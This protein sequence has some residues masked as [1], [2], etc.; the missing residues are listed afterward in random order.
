M[1]HR[2][3]P[4]FA[5][6]ARCELL[7]P[8]LLLSAV[9][10]AGEQDGHDHAVVDFYL[11]T[12]YR[13][14]GSGTFLTGPTA[15]E[16]FQIASDYLAAHADDLGLTASDL[17]G[18]VVSSQYTDQ[19]SGVTHIYLR[20]THDGL[21]V[22]NADLSVNV[23]ALGEIINVSS[24][25]IG[26]PQVVSGLTSEFLIG[27]P[28][29]FSELCND[30]GLTLSA[31]DDAQAKLVYVPTAEGLELAWRLN[32]QTIDQAHW[33][34]AFVEAD[35]GEPIYVDDLSSDFASYNVFASP[36][37]SPNEG[38][39]TLVVDP[40]DA[41]ASP[42]GW[43][44]TNG[45][46]GAEFTDTRGNNASVQEDADHNDTGG[47][48]PDGGLSLTFDFPLDTSQNPANFQSAA[49]TNMF[50]WI[51][52]LHDI[53]YQYGFTEAAGNFQVNN[54]GHG[55]T[56]N[57][58]VMGDIQDG[59]GGGPSFVTPPDG[60]S[61]RMQMYLNATVNP[62]RDSALDNTVLI[63]EYGHG[64]SERLTGGPAMTSGLNALQSTG[65]SE[66][67]SDWWALMLTQD[68]SD[69]KTAAYPVGNWYFGQG[70]NG[71][72]ARRFPYSFDMSVNPLTMADFNNATTRTSRHKMGEVW[73]SALWDMNWLLID[74]YGFSSD[75]YH[76][77]GGNNLALQLVMDALKLQG[78]NPSYLDGRDAIL[79][80]DLAL[81]GGQNQA[82]IWTAFARRG[83]GFSASDGGGASATSVTEAFDIPGTISGT[84]FR[85]D[86]ADGTRDAGEPGL[87]GWTVYR[88]LNNNGVQDVATVTTFNSTDIPKA[89]TDQGL[90]FSNIVISG[91]SGSIV[92]VNIAVSITHPNDADLN[93][94]LI[95][96]SGALVILS[97]FLGGT[98]DN[99]TSTVFDDE[100]ATYVTSASAPFTGSF[101]PFFSLSQLDGNSPNG[102]WKLRV[103][104]VAAGNTGTLLGWSMQVSYGNPDPTAVTDANGNYTFFGSGN[105][106]HH[107]R[108]IVQP[109]FTRTAPA[110]GVLDV[111]ISSGQPVNGQNF[112]NRAAASVSNTS[113]LEDTLSSA[114]VLNPPVSFGTT[115]FKISGITGGTLFQNNGTTPINNGDFITVAQGQAG[116]K[117]LPSANSNSTGSFVVELSKN[118]TSVA[119]DASPATCSITVTPVGDTPQVANITTLED[120]LSGAIVVNRNANDGTE[121]THFKI[122]DITGG[123][124]FKND[125][126]TPISNNSFLTF[127]EAQAGVKFLP[128]SN[129]TTSG[130]FDVESSQNGSTVAAQSGKATSTINVTPVG[131]TPQVANIATLENTLSGAI[132]LNRHAA[133]GSEVTH[134]RISGITNGTLFKND[135]VT[136]I[137]NGDFLLFAEGQS[138]VKFLPA[139]N[140]TAT[141][142]FD[143]ESSQDG[144]TVA[145]QSGKATSTITVTASLSIAD[146]SVVE[147]DAGQ[148]LANFTVMLSGVSGQTVTVDFAT[149]SNTAIAASDYT[150]STGTL[151]FAPGETIKSITVPILGDIWDEVDESFFVNLSNASNAVIADGQAIGTITD[152]DAAPS[153]SINDISVVEGNSGQ[154]TASFTVILSATS[155]QAV[156]VDYST[157]DQTAGAPSDYSAVSGTLTFAPGETTKTITV[158]I[159]PDAIDELDETFVANLSNAINATITDSQGSGTIT[160]DDPMP[161][162]SIGDAAVLEGNA[163]QT[164]MTFTVTL[165]TTSSRTISVA[166]VTS[167]N[168]ATAPIEYSAN[169]GSLTFAPGETTKM[170]NVQVQGDVLD[171]THETFFVNLSNATN[172]SLLDGQAIGTITDDDAT[173]SLSINDVA[174][175]EGNSGTTTATF[176]VTLSAISAQTVTVDY[177]TA[178]NTATVASD[179]SASFGTL[180]FAPGE[181]T[182]TIAVEVLGDTVDEPNETFQVNLTGAVG[183]IISDNR[184]IGTITD[185]DGTPTLSVN[186]VIVTEGEPSAI[187]TVTLSAPSSQLVTVNF[188]T[189]S[190]TAFQDFIATSGTL[191]FAAGE[192]SKSITVP[193]NEDLF[194][195]ADE[196]FFVVLSTATNATVADGYGAA[197]ILD[198]DEAPSLSISNSSVTEGNSGTTLATFT[199]TLSSA[200][201]RTVMV[202]YATAD[203]TAL[204]ASDYT[205]TFGTLT[206]VAGLTSKT[207]TIPILGDLL[208][209]PNETFHLNLS[210]AIN[211]SILG[212]QGLGAILDND[213]SPSLSINDVTVV[214]GNSGETSATFTVKLSAV[215]GQ[216]VTVNYATAN[217]TA[218]ATADYAANSGMLTFAAGETTKTITVQ[219]TGDSLDESNESFFVNLS[220][221]VNATILDSQ[222]LGTISD[223]DDAPSLSIDDVVVSE[224]SAGATT[225]TFTV[226]LATASGQAV[227]V[228]YGTAN[229]TAL[230]PADYTATTGT[231]TFPAGT[232]TQPISVAIRPDLIDEL[233][234]TFFVI[235][236]GATN[237]S[238]AD[239]RATGTI[240]D[241]DAPPTMSIKDVVVYE[242]NSG[243]ALATFTVS[244]S[245]ASSHAISV[246]YST[247][248]N[249]A[250]A[251]VDYAATSG[252]LILAAGT[253]SKNFTVPIFGDVLDEANE[254]FF[255]NL[256]NPI[257]ASLADDQ[258]IGTIND[259]DAAPSLKIN[260]VT[261]TEGNSGTANAT[262]TVTLSAA[263]GQAVGV[264]F[265][266]ANSTAL[267]GNDYEAQSGTLLFAPGEKT[268]TVAIAVIGDTLDEANE[269]YF[270][271]LSSATNASLADS[272]GTG[273]ITDNDAAPTLSIN[274][275]TILEGHSG[276]TTATFTV[277]LSA[278]SGQTVS[279]KYATANNT[280]TASADYTAT[281]GTLTFAAGVVSKTITVSIRGDLL[282]ELDEFFFVNLTNP[283]NAS[284]ADSQ[285]RGTITDDD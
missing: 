119:T 22:M 78:T 198:N 44:D 4:S 106:T 11:P 104:D 102:T 146:T 182:K 31:M 43:H 36:L 183:G 256:S 186:D 88:D 32:V 257:N 243:Q 169:S 3:S 77:T 12:Q 184:G 99:Y 280:A 110:S 75:F 158:P 25:F 181:T 244:L 80:A 90:I 206:L 28:Q 115:H 125:G 50:F 118:G 101:K 140:S 200:S 33:F 59:D 166:F 230:A 35:S 174:V 116:V 136:P 1:S 76:G 20:Q 260:D 16:P 228:K 144:T 210:N 96:P 216:A 251:G 221:A 180:T 254:T 178:D 149:A 281:S 225:A 152:N 133:D 37:V 279:V 121:V 247:A 143:V 222:G 18:Y 123:T 187:F 51:N 45:V 241:D 253:T 232:T 191:N 10:D 107:V 196:T 272:S 205:A 34:D 105:G 214:E 185:D 234:E 239:N 263:S 224:G 197:T 63:H 64:I 120:T 204:A 91:L 58:P 74:K 19:P 57:D 26:D 194:D 208:D 285:G 265:T 111:V 148:I 163:G 236:L 283:I 132:V 52:R 135:G 207:F 220:S 53:H 117:F 167:D 68:G 160:D 190:G 211:A 86:D 164:S 170:I 282:N 212:D 192:I 156:T 151:T 268:K 13:L 270:V 215:S 21:E 202:D 173:P 262:F 15:G 233:D 195:E 277:T 274:D 42:F 209:E 5:D 203:G 95:S 276:L 246:D 17:A 41:T 67:W 155:G 66:G 235:L 6:L 213:P 226:R 219:I 188:F 217:S 193:L 71:G 227:T 153:L 237:A 73:C 30:L 108:E 172:A 2:R 141:G 84:V 94:A 168:T 240:T 48:R 161:S 47:S 218:I 112:G 100:A 250:L 255:V 130:K 65:L 70:L 82:E 114:I 89:I 176:T 49:A 122:S 238:I 38:G 278:A 231:L 273:T 147:G 7:E 54:Y 131:D 81:T 229:S 177:S 103:D 259:N 93:L 223:D 62:A 267:A 83:M 154:P 159:N 165:S 40:Q 179:Y 201:G 23:T 92:D 142:H 162:L 24:S 157:A 29:A 242:G 261:I 60:Q 199:V 248:N 245:A 124:L 284:L 98:G 14:H 61:P 252:T 55:G 138:G 271:K 79:A 145:A 266:T 264:N 258:A 72:G 97:Q 129:S 171:E 139:V 189:T 46:A 8:R 150:A 175:L 249:T 126:V 275:V 39:R 113:T 109:G 137:N 56:A 128:S 85:D 134:F 87:P 69:T 127:A 9:A 27:A 269:T